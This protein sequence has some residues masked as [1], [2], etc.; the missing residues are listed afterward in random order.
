M[1]CSF[2]EFVVFAVGVVTCLMTGVGRANACEPLPCQSGYLLPVDGTV[3]EN[4]PGIVWKAS[5]PERRSGPTDPLRD[6]KTP[7]RPDDIQVWRAEKAG[8]KKMTVRSTG[9]KYSRR[10]KLVAVESGWREGQ[11]YQVSAGSDCPYGAHGRGRFEGKFSI[12]PKAALPTTLG[13][14]RAKPLTTG[15]L[16][17]ASSGG[18]CRVKARVAYIDLVLVPSEEAK[19]WLSVLEYETLVDGKRVHISDALNVAAPAWSSWVGKGRDRL[20]INCDKEGF[21]GLSKGKHRVVMAATIAGSATRVSTP[22]IEVVLSC[23][24]PDPKAPPTAEDPKPK[25]GPAGGCAVGGQRGGE[26][27]AAW[28]LMLIVCLNGRRRKPKEPHGPSS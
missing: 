28:A 27:M 4:A 8:K 22:A 16:T 3:P 12:G 7:N 9:G 14:L 18:G 5:E 15:R 23:G 21:A 20:Y 26:Q 24:T 11:R 6:M 2:P 25:Q 19:P 13:T 1:R 10:G 17:V